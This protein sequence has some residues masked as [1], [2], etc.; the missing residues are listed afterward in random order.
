MYIHPDAQGK[1]SEVDKDTKAVVD[2]CNHIIPYF[3][4]TY[5]RR[6]VEDYKKYLWY[7]WDR[8]K[9]IMDWQSNIHI[10][11]VATYADTMYNSLYDSK[12]KFNILSDNKSLSVLLNKAF[13]RDNNWRNTVLDAAREAIITGKGFVKPY[14]DIDKKKIVIGGKDYW[15]TTKMPQMAY[16]SI[17][18]VFYDYNTTI[19]DSAFV[20]ERHILWESAIKK[21]YGRYLEGKEDKDKYLE[22]IISSCPIRFSDYD[23]NRV[24]NIL[25]YEEDI[26]KNKRV[27]DVSITNTVWERNRLEQQ[28]RWVDSTSSIDTHNNIFAVDFKKNRKFEVL[29]YRDEDKMLVFIDGKL[30]VKVPQSKFTGRVY[31]ISFGRVPGTSD[32]TGIAS[33]VW[34]LQ[35]TINTLQNIFLDGLKMDAAP[36]FEQ[37]GWLNQM[38]GKKNT[39]EYSPYKIIPTNTAGSLKKIELG[40]GWF[41]PINA[42]QF[43]EWVA[44]KRIWVNEYITGGQGKVERV[45]GW[46]ELIYNQ[47]KSRLM[48][49]TDSINQVMSNIAKEYLIMFAQ[50]F[51]KEELTKIGLE[52]EYTIE[53]IVNEENVTFT[54]TA[55]ALLEK[56]ELFSHLLENMPSFVGLIN[57]AR[58]ENI[59]VKELIR[60]ILTKEVDMEKIL[61]AEPQQEMQPWMEW[62]QQMS[63]LQSMAQ[64]AR[65]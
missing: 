4:Q 59:S 23:Y 46:V 3:H 43:L 48:P 24:K 33:N 19:E 34:D 21:R 16:V 53:Q 10:P 32:S 6:Y 9:L 37:I 51:T 58:G 18:D 17:F 38:L 36:M 7:K 20:I 30:L 49:I 41:E 28:L 65:Y 40:L 13:D 15:K 50:Y 57:W 47:Y 26:V 14:L 1:K 64:Q 45:A 11:L 29:E 22:G 2:I 63:G 56:E 27:A 35:V 52:E 39:I 54:L 5:F 42:N 44:E 60:A 12:M 8:Q 31:D 62:Q 25:S 55:L 61:N